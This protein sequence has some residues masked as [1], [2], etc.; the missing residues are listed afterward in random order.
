MQYFLFPGIRKEFTRDFL[1]VQWLVS[2]LPMQGIQVQSLVWEDLTCLGTAEPA[3]H[4]Y[5][6]SALEPVLCDKRG[7]SNEKPRPAA[8]SKP[9]S[10]Q[11]KPAR[12]SED[13]V[14]PKLN[15]HRHK[16]K[17]TNRIR[18]CSSK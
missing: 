9:C 18:Q 17:K 6:A 15:K 3:D 8:K 16:L 10:L 12:I 4:N 2:C 7:H 13:P 14:Q 1:W 5:R 11:R